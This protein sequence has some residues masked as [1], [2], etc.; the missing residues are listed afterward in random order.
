MRK[1]WVAAGLAVSL[2][3][4]AAP[5]HAAYSERCD[6]ETL[7]AMAGDDVTVAFATREVFADR[8]D[9][10]KDENWGC[11]VYGYVTTRDPGPNKVLFTLAMPDNFSGRYVF[12]GIG[13]AAG[14]LP[15]MEQRLLAKGYALAG[16][17]AGTG[18]KSIADFSFMSD[19]A[20]LTDFMWR[21]V[22]TSAEATQAIARRYYAREKIYRYISGCSGGGQMGL[23]NARRFGGEDFDGFLVG[24]TPFQ[25]SLYLPNVM[26][27]A[28]HL[29]NKPSGWIPPELIARAGE[30]ILE[31]YDGV[32][33]ASDGLIRDQRNIGTFD[34]DILRKAGF[35]E[36]QVET[37]NLIRN[38]WKFPSGG[39]AGD[40]VHPG[41]SI[42]D[43]SGWTRFLLGRK[44]PPWP[45][46]RTGSPADM[47]QQGVSFIHIMT[48]TKTRAVSPETDYWKV[49]DFD[50]MVRLT[51]NDGQ[52]MPFADP[53]DYSTF[54]GS[55]A[56]MIIWH[57]VNDESMSYLESLSGY[58]ALRGRFHDSDNW[59]RYMAFPGMWHCRGG[60][61]PTDHV[62]Q[63]LEAMI[64]WVER[65]EAPEAIV[66]NRYLR[67]EGLA[68]SFLICAEPKRAYLKQAGL[69][70]DDA[71]NWECRGP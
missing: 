68:R 65:G 20:K 23:G 46:T 1:R 50:E 44:P 57:G 43:I 39:N 53:M 40:G 9:V 16:T 71:K 11:H 59:L 30:A 25:G 31:A 29:Q 64:G 61:G 22:R 51:S 10:Y 36:D 55:G 42:T 67:E 32:D 70:P 18:A 49:T 45:D 28:A 8:D 17:D 33:G 5:A 56:R 4:G 21:G 2:L 7:Q 14:K 19:E 24:A 58:E 6:T 35:S 27:I 38:T 12:L 37:F 26:R 63:I 34:E 15:K 60:T 52:T 48:D 3:F 66:A 13:G 54:A 62:E 47:L 41:F 69:D